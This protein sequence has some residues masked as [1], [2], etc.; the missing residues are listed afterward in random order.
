MLRVVE[1]S[2]P[3]SPIRCHDRK[4][5][6]GPSSPYRADIPVGLI[7]SRLFAAE[8]SKRENHWL[9]LLGKKA[10]LRAG[11]ILIGTQVLEQ[12]LDVD[13]DLLFSDLAPVDLLLQR[14]G[15]LWRH[16]RENRAV[17]APRSVPDHQDLSEA[18][19]AESLISLIG[20]NSAAIYPPHLL[21]WTHQV[22]TGKKMLKLPEEISRLIEAVYDPD[23]PGPSFIQALSKQAE[24][25]CKEAQKLALAAGADSVSLPIADD[26]YAKTR[27][28]S[29]ETVPA[30]LANAIDG[31]LISLITGQQVKIDSKPSRT[32]AAR[33]AA[34]L[35]LATVPVP[36]HHLPKNLKKPWLA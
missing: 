10:K 11:C 16:Q 27:W 5:I 2:W 17:A 19:S 30:V 13:F 9:A 25:E 26:D 29:M 31:E 7:H 22:L 32:D 23:D 8:R 1:P 24:T 3:S 15:R 12:S 20:R 35:A 34:K 28:G 6:S 33:V 4:A 18:T 36:R 14:L 21:W